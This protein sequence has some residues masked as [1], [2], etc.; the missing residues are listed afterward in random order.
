MNKGLIFSIEEFSVYDGPGIRTAVFFK[1]CPLR[2]N[3]CHNPEGL[4]AKPQIVRSPNGCLK[5][6]RCTAEAAKHGGVLTKE[7]IS[8]CPQHLIRE[9][10]VYYTA[11]ELEKKLLKN[12]DILTDGG[13]G[14]TF[15]GGECLMQIDFLTEMAK[16]LHGKV[17]LAIETSGYADGE[18]FRELLKY[19][20][21]VMFD[22][23]II[24][25]DVFREYIGA[26]NTRILEN[27]GILA[28]NRVTFVPRTPL[29]PGVTDTTENLEAIAALVAGTHAD[30]VELLPYN[31]MAGSKYKMLEK[32]YKPKFD[33]T[34]T[35]NAAT[36]IF[37]K[38]GIKT[39]IM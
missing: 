35:P 20:D 18:K 1:G 27:F 10:G 26:D 12:A 24:D 16:R 9:S 30:H 19:L 5:C 13:G 14:I 11:D 23:K 28:E 17:H 33:E 15:S 29:I 37:E 2:C 25:K 4:E 34:K 6:G 8:V 36:E 21:L 31:K 39:K 38:Y 22:L 32:D 7:C 3:W